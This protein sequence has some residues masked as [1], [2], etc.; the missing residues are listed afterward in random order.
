MKKKVTLTQSGK[1]DSVLEALMEV[2]SDDPF[3]NQKHEAARIQMKRISPVRY[4]SFF[5][6]N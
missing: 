3:F 6:D 1:F 4:A 2:K 5:G